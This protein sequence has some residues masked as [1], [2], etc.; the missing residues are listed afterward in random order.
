LP[1]EAGKGRGLDADEADEFPPV[2]KSFVEQSFSPGED[3]IIAGSWLCGCGT[4]GYGFEVGVPKFQGYPPC[5][6]GLIA[7][8]SPNLL[9]EVAKHGFEER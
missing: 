1:A 2:R 4:A 3:D 5:L 7:Q 8:F 6:S 9:A